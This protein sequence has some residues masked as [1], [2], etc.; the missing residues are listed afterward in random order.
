MVQVTGYRY[1]NQ[2][3]LKENGEWGMMKRGVVMGLIFS[4][5]LSVVV[6]TAKPVMAV[7]SPEIVL[8]GQRL[9]LPAGEPGPVISSEGRVLVPARWIAEALG[10]RVSWQETTRQAVFEDAH[11]QT[12]LTI[13]SSTAQIGQHTV[14]LDSPAAVLQGRTYVPL[15]F[16]TEAFGARVAWDPQARQVNIESFQSLTT[17][18]KQLFQIQ[19]IGLGDPAALVV[20]L[21]GEPL[22][23]LPSEYAF[24]WWIYHDNY[25]NYVQVGVEKDRVAALYTNGTHWESDSGLAAGSLQTAVRQILG[26][27][28]EWIEKGQN[29]YLRDGKKHSDLFLLEDIAYGEFYYDIHENH[30]VTAIQVILKQSEESMNGFLGNQRPELEKSYSRQL[31]LLANALRTRM[32]LPAFQWNEQA[33]QAAEKHSRDMGVKDYFS[34]ET[35]EGRTFVQRL[36]AEGLRFTKAGENIAANLNAIN[37]HEALMNSP[38]HRANLLSDMTHL[39]TGSSQGH[40]GTFELLHTQKFLSF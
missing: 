17:R 7:S 36:T 23:K 3:I 8:D 33:A 22:E 13:G 38:G 14:R 28:L 32:G 10:L 2:Q 30:Q 34:H 1:L 40:Q 25:R 21:W 24:E 12:V 39:G 5:A 18:L 6:L 9:L 11:Q 37:A 35:P 27:P 16:V 31:F 15:R 4:L 29:R 20:T 26:K 19:G